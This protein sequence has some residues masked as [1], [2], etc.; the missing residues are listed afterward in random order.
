MDQADFTNIVSLTPLVSIDMVVR[1]TRGQVLLG[2]RNNRPAQHTW[3]VPGGRIRRNETML[4]AWARIAQTELGFVLPAPK[5]LG[6]FEHFYSN[7]NTL[8]PDIGTHYVVIACT[9][10]I[11]ADTTISGDQ[12]HAKWEWWSIAQLL[13]CPDVHGNTKAY[14]DPTSTSFRLPA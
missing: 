9:A 14:F 3:F 12:Q 5:L 2:Y 7:S 10:K 11:E 6:V 8:D 1:N 4:G 13:D